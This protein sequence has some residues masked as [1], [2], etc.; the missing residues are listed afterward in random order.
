[1]V[2]INTVGPEIRDKIK[3]YFTGELDRKINKFEKKKNTEWPDEYYNTLHSTS[4]IIVSKNSNGIGDP[5]G[6][7]ATKLADLSKCISEDYL[8]FKQLKKTIAETLEQLND[9]DIYLL[10]V[11]LELIEGSI[12]AAAK[13]LNVG[14]SKARKKIKKLLMMLDRKISGVR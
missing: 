13:K 9:K 2:R 6:E 7:K 3:M 5:A 1:M 10:K 4:C 14:Y 12:K 8:Y 11:K